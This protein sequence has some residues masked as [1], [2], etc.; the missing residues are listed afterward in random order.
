[1][2]R[3][4]LSLIVVNDEKTLLPR[5]GRMHGRGQVGIEG[6]LRLLGTLF[7]EDYAC[8]HAGEGTRAR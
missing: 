6:V 2:N 1:M 5:E 8:V 3:Q 7:R 4:Y